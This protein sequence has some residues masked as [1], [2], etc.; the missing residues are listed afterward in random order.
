MIKQ[1]RGKAK[2]GQHKTRTVEN[3]TKETKHR[4]NNTGAT[5]NIYKKKNKQEYN[6]TITNKQ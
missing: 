5:L 2:H 1:N 3:N 6:K 4:T